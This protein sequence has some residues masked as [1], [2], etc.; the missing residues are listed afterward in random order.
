MRN[1][2][3]RRAKLTKFPE[4]VAVPAIQMAEAIGQASD[5]LASHGPECGCQACE[6][7]QG[8]SGVLVEWFGKHC[9]DRLSQRMDRKAA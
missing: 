7:Y 3:P 4:H 9:P 5:L 8:L 6:L 2:P 1:K